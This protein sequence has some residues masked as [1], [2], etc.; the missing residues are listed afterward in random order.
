MAASK[1]K[2]DYSEEGGKFHQ[3]GKFWWWTWK[4]ISGFYHRSGGKPAFIGSDGATEWYEHG[5]L[6]NEEGPSIVDSDGTYAYHFRGMHHNLQGPAL[7]N[8]S[9]GRTLYYIMG[10]MYK[11]KEDFLDARDAYCKEHNIP[12][13]TEDE[14]RDP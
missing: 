5:K 12:I 11:T 7:Y 9:T 4:D 1:E 2:V 6:H 10:K 13:P 14:A 3:T 8:A